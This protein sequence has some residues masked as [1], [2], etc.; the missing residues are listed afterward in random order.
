MTTYFEAPDGHDEST[1]WTTEVDHPDYLIPVLRE[2]DAA[3][4]WPDVVAR[5]TGTTVVAD[6]ATV[7]R[8]AA[9]ISLILGRPWDLRPS[10]ERFTLRSDARAILAAL[11]DDE[12]IDPPG[13][14]VT[15]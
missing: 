15:E 8:V 11:K 14:V 5:M 9:R 7:E 12:N 1:I 4:F 13:W 10:D 2:R 6:D 3:P